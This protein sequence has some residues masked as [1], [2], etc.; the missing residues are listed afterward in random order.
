MTEKFRLIIDVEINSDAC[1]K[2]SI[3]EDEVLESLE[4]RP[5]KT[6]GTYEIGP[7]ISK[8]GL[9][10][11]IFSK[12]EIID[13]EFF[14][15]PSAWNAEEDDCRPQKTAAKSLP[16]GWTWTDYPDGSG[17]ISSPDGK[18]YYAYDLQ[19][20][21]YQDCRTKKWEFWKDYPLPM[22]LKDFK[23]DTEERILDELRK[24]K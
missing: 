21:E 10:Q 18:E 5:G 20:H 24:K 23:E 7:D 6:Q 9:I 12:A 15:D 2:R 11:D 14:S 4:I 1:K 17:G 22:N 13:K 19:T 8:P 3:T 16:D